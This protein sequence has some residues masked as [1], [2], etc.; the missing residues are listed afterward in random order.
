MKHRPQ[1]SFALSKYDQKFEAVAKWLACGCGTQEDVDSR[2]AC[3]HKLGVSVTT[4]WPK[5]IYMPS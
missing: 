3:H 5:T 1:V 2:S 4:E